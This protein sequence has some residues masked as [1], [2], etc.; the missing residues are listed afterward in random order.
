MPRSDGIEWLILSA[1]LI[2]IA[3]GTVLAFGL[4]PR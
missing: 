1:I 2:G 3:L 4:A